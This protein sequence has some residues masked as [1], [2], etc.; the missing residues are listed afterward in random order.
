MISTETRLRGIII[1]EV[2]FKKNIKAIVSANI[3][4][5]KVEI[6]SCTNRRFCSELKIIEN[7]TCPA[8]CEVIVAAKDYAFRRRIPKAVVAEIEVGIIN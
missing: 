3:L 8:Y 6:V 5:K 1:L 2:K 7:G 4:E